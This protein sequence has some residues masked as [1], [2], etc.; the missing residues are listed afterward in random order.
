M[1]K[2]P[3]ETTVVE[4]YKFFFTRFLSIIGTIWFPILVFAAIVAGFAAA[5]VPHEW[6][7]GNF[8]P[9][10]DPEIFF[11]SR[12]GLIVLAVFCILI[13]GLVIGAMIR[14]GVLRVALGQTTGTT[15]FYFS[16]GAPVWRMI[17]AQ[18]LA[19]II[20]ICVVFA[21]AFVV[22]LI[23]GVLAAIPN[24]PAAV[25]ILVNVVLAIAAIIG[26]F[27][28]LA[29]LVFFL[30]AVVVAENRIGLGR[31]WALGAGNVLRIIV[32]FL[33]VVIP[34]YIVFNIAIYGV[35]FSTLAVH[36]DQLAALPKDDPDPAEVFAILKLMLP[37]LPVMIGVI[38]LYALAM[39][40][41]ML[42]AI[43]KG[44]KAVAGEETV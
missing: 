37:M 20:G 33:A 21:A 9:V 22:G 27:Y 19:V 10:Q 26:V 40:G 15:L 16:L 14:V 35:M 24:T 11:S 4:A 8:Q 42:G 1:K 36:I 28:F 43:A 2:L 30:P 3:I 41:T 34:I 7:T 6:L 38:I 25:T 12:L 23:N 31:S 18:L 13:A 29:R 5:I 44:Y 39:M 32:V 17:A